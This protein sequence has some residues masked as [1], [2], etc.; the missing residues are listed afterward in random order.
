MPEGPSIVILREAAAHLAGMRVRHATGNARIDTARIVGKTI[1]ALRSWGKHFLIEFDTFSLRVHFL[2]FGSYRLDERRA[3][4]TPRLSLAGARGELHL[5]ACALRFIEKPLDSVYDWRT[6][7]MSDQW[8]A[9]RARRKLGEM[10][11]TLVCD[12]L[13][14]QDVFA[15]VGNIIKNEVL[16]RIRVHPL[17]TLEALPDAQR[18]ALVREARRYAFE[19]LAWKK[20]GVLKQHWLAHTKRVCPRCD[21]ALQQATL[22][23]TRRRT[24]YCTQ[25]QVRYGAA[26]TPPNGR[27]PAERARIG[28]AA[29][30]RRA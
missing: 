15:G 22:G 12:A 14:D 10:P 28:A 1:V 13:L 8:S 19:F 23:K 30:K 7:V 16:F 21:V 18:A 2:L 5:Y 26:E 29:R 17:S 9:A 6:D 25:C 20:A 11:Q 3:G 4:V 27:T 24:F